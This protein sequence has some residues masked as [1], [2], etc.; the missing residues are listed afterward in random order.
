MTQMNQNLI[1]QLISDMTAGQEQA[2]QANLDRYEQLLQH[3]SGLGQQLEGTLAGIGEAAGQRI[4][5]R[6]VQQ[7]RQA[8][9]QAISRGIGSTTVAPALQ[10]GVA[11]DT[12]AQRQDLDAQLAQQRLGV[13]QQVGQ[14]TAGAIEGRQDVGP[15]MGAFLGLIQQLAGAQQQPLQ[16]TVGASTSGLP[17]LATSVRQQGTGGRPQAAAP[18]P[19]ANRAVL[20]GPSTTA[21]SG[22]QQHQANQAR[23]FGPVT[24]GT[25]R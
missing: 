16:A 21:R 23:T 14:M 22:W 15:D 18:S 4:E 19:T 2:R 7:G 12:E 13:Q 10:R 5:Q 6:G 24:G 25:G 9:Q 11:A 17:D 1:Q 8:E 20:S 3:I